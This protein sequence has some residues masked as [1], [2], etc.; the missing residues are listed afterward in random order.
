MRW[1]GHK[2]QMLQILIDTTWRLVV[3]GH[4]TILIG[5]AAPDQHFH[6]IA[7]CV[8]SKEDTEGHLHCLKQ[9]KAGVEAV[10]ALYTLEQ[11]TM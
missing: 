8:V 2:I 5:V 7:Y 3:E 10:M 9:V 6:A 1:Q 11:R 4:G